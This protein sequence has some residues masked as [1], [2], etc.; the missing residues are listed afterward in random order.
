[1]LLILRSSSASSFFSASVA[2]EFPCGTWSARGWRCPTG[3]GNGSCLFGDELPVCAMAAGPTVS[4]SSVAVTKSFRIW[5]FRFDAPP[6]ESGTRRVEMNITAIIHDTIA[7]FGG[8]FTICG[9]R[10]FDRNVIGTR[11]GLAVAP[12]DIDHKFRLT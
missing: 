10:I 2:A 5:F 9:Q 12:G 11:W 1:M 3:A 6:L 8:L 7:G 4:I